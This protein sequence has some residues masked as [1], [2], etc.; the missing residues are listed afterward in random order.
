MKAIKERVKKYARKVWRG[1]TREYGSHMKLT[2]CD[3][4]AGAQSEREELTRWRNPNE[5]LPE[6]N[7]CV[8]MKVSD[9]EH[10]RI[11]LG[12][13]QDDVRMCDGG[14]SFCQNEK[15]VSDTMVWLSAGDRFTKTNRTMDIL[16]PHDGVTNDKIAKAQI[17]AVERKQNEYKLIGQ[18]VR[19]PGHTLYKFNTV[20][21]TASR[22]EVEVSA[23]SW[24]NPKNM[25]VES[26]RKSHVKVEKDCYYEQALNMKNFI[27]RLRRRGIVG[28][29]EEVKLER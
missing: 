8:L 28:M 3:F 25:K 21:R 27:K 9:G 4:I 6:N 15:S 16:T 7:S 14:Y 22:A 10:E 24:L 18:M 5:E 26:D 19:V 1:G 20:T 12:A 29:D 17:E 11:Y 2:E 23:Y 13:R